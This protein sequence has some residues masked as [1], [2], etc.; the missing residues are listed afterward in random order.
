M[1]LDAAEARELARSD[2]CIGCALRPGSL[3]CDGCRDEYRRTGVLPDLLD[4]GRAL[5]G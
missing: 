2:L 4:G 1:T 3:W 5:R